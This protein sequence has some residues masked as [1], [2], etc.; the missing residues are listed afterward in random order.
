MLEA[1]RFHAFDDAA[2]ALRALRERGTRL[3][4]A[5]NWDCSLARV[6]E[7]AGLGGLLD[8]VVSS[9]MAGAAKPRRELFMAALELAR[10]PPDRAIYVGDSPANDVAGAAAAG[11][12]AILLRRGADRLDRTCADASA[13]AE[14]VAVIAGLDQLPRV[15]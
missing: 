2:P 12:R 1:I 3:V 6:L 10:T 9:A 8:G 11:L 14:P 15:I 13:T 4:V 7:Q 5:S